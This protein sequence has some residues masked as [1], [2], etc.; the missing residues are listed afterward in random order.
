MFYPTINKNFKAMKKFKKIT[1]QIILLL[2]LVTSIQCSKEDAV[3]GN[4]N[5]KLINDHLADLPDWNNET[6][7]PLADE[8][9]NNN[10]VRTENNTPYKYDIVKRNMTNS[11][12]KIIAVGTNSGKM[13]PGALIQGKSLEAGDLELINT[14]RAPITINVDLPINKTFREIETPNS[15][16]IQQAISEMQVEAGQLEEGS[17]SGAGTMDFEVVEASTFE[18]SMLSLGISG[19]FTDPESQVGLDAS[20]NVSHNRSIKTHTVAARFVQEKFTVRLA[21]DLIPT[22]SDFFS[23]DMTLQEIEALSSDWGEDNIPMYIESVTYGRILIFTME[24]TEVNDAQVL[25]AALTASMD[26]YVKAGGSIDDTQKEILSNSTTKIFSA[27]GTE[28]GANAA[29]A[30]LDWSK[31][32]VP[33]PVST[34]V[35]I[36][37]TIRTLNGKK[38]VKIHDNIFFEL[39]DHFRA[40]KSYDIKVTLNEATLTKGICAACYYTS[41]FKEDGSATSSVLAAGQ[42]YLVWNAGSVGGTSSTTGKSAGSSF[43][44]I[45]GY[46]T[47]PA[48]GYCAIQDLINKKSNSYSWPYTDLVSGNTNLT[49]TI[50]ENFRALV[51]KYT[52]RKTANY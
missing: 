46:C 9:V 23:D 47:N 2:V 28:E 43:E 24:S 50:N 18:Q 14:K 34:T 31:F 10:F 41:R 44:I 22:A 42:I 51:F 7:L 5:A 8:I 16:T 11:T 33:A 32:F 52:I 45:S 25:S 30:S 20:A 3:V 1:I 40:P 39:R 36:A 37:F 6:T 19:G 17:Q 21:D 29:I 38:T 27:G 4:P 26:D 15:V 49:V 12:A 35:P 13:W 48:P